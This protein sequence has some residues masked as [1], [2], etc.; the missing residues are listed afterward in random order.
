MD[1]GDDEDDDA[2]TFEEALEEQ[3]NLTNKRIIH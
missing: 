1:E 3:H 2:E